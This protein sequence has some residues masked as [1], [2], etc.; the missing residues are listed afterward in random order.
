M[1]T[2]DATVIDD[3]AS[4][5]PYANHFVTAVATQV[6][7]SLDRVEGLDEFLDSKSTDFETLLWD[8]CFG[9]LSILEA[10]NEVEST[11]KPQEPRYAV[12]SFADDAKL[13]KHML[14]ASNRGHLHGTSLDGDAIEKAMRAVGR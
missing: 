3:D 11:E 8:I 13:P 6:A 9:A 5:L 10:F 1:K 7:R 14:M 4:F 2:I 12:L